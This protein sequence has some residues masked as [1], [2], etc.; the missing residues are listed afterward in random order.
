MCVCM[1]VRLASGAVDLI[2]M[3][4]KGAVEVCVVCACVC[5]SPESK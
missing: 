2:L 5:V 4:R 3:D 1:R